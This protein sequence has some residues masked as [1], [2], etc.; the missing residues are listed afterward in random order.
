MK[1]WRIYRGRK[2]IFT[3][4]EIH[5]QA[6]RQDASS[7]YSDIKLQLSS[8]F[9]RSEVFSVCT[10]TH[11]AGIPVSFIHFAAKGTFLLHKQPVSQNYL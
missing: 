3:I 7:E 10:T 6:I 9:Y 11:K 5:I 1:V 8:L 4:S 2:M